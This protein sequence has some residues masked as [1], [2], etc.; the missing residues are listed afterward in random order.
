MPKKLLVFNAVAKK[1]TTKKTHKDS[2]HSI[3]K[4]NTV[5]KDLDMEKCI[6]S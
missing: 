2:A 1:H 6:A 4:F 3:Y 5:H